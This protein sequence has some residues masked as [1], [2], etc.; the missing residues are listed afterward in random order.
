[1]PVSGWVAN[2]AIG[3]DT[4][5]FGG[6]TLPAIAPVSETWEEVGFAIHRLSAQGLIAVIVLHVGGA[7][8][9]AL[10]KRDGTL[11]QMVRGS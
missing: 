1:M 7:L 2:S 3:I 5:I 11:R 4:V 8:F 6:W 10:V 9:H